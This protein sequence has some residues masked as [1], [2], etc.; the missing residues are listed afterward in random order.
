S[1]APHEAPFGMYIP[2]FRKERLL[3]PQDPAG[4]L[5]RLAW[6]RSALAPRLLRGRQYAFRALSALRWRPAA[7][8]TQQ[9]GRWRSG[10]RR[11]PFG[12]VLVASDGMRP[13]ASRWRPLVGAG[14]P[15]AAASAARA[16][17]LDIDHLCAEMTFSSSRCSRAYS[18][19]SGFCGRGL[20]PRF[21]GVNPV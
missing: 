21:L 13:N 1:G 14:R 19:A 12:E 8:W 15:S 6:P 11:A 18:A 17:Y 2:G 16:R 9:P 7:W 3:R 5:W 10:A 4:R 20:R